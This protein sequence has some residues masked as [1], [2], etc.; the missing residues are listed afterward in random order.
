[1]FQRD[2]NKVPIVPV[3]KPA[4]PLSRLPEPNA[5]G[6]YWLTSQHDTRSPAIFKINVWQEHLGKYLAIPGGDDVILMSGNRLAVFDT[7]V[8]ALAALR[9][10]RDA[11]SA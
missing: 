11:R 1:M 9:K 10:A 6:D 4:D 3:I 8:E 5:H 7:P 2:K